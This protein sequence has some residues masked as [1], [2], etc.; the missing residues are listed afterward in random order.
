MRLHRRPTAPISQALKL[1]G[2]DKTQTET[3]ECLSEAVPA[4][5]EHVKVLGS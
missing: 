3:P 4:A 5:I 1:K 2:I